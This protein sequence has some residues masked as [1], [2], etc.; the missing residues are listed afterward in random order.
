ME[1]PSTGSRGER[2]ELP[3]QTFAN[4]AEELR[5]YRNQRKILRLMYENVSRMEAQRQAAILLV[6][7]HILGAEDPASELT[8]LKK[9]E[10]RPGRACAQ[11]YEDSL[12]D[13][14][15]AR[16]AYIRHDLEDLN[17]RI[18]SQD[19]AQTE[20]LVARVDRSLKEA[21]LV[22]DWQL[23][24]VESVVGI[25][26][27][28]AQQLGTAEL[29]KLRPV[30]YSFLPHLKGS[31]AEL[32]QKWL[33]LQ[34]K[35]AVAHRANA[36]SKR[37]IDQVVPSARR[38]M[39]ESSMQSRVLRELRSSRSDFNAACDRLDNFSIDDF[40]EAFRL[41]PVADPDDDFRVVNWAHESCDVDLLKSEIGH[42]HRIEKHV[43][44][45]G[46]VLEGVLA[47]GKLVLETLLEVAPHEL[48]KEVHSGQVPADVFD[49][50]SDEHVA[51]VTTCLLLNGYRCSSAL[52]QRLSNSLSSGY[53]P[54]SEYLAA[55][56]FDVLSRQGRDVDSTTRVGLKAA[57]NVSSF[58]NAC[59][60]RGGRSAIEVAEVVLNVVSAVRSNDARAGSVSSELDEQLA[61]CIERNPKLR[62]W[63]NSE[64]LVI[65]Q[66]LPLVGQS[67]TIVANQEM[68]NTG[69]SS[70]M[71]D[72]IRYGR[73][74]AGIQID[75]IGFG[76]QRAW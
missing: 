73:L 4:L 39:S 7:R 66:E 51:I 17:H 45:L 31:A 27:H 3:G 23:R 34:Q 24:D 61:V 42:V 40:P 26:P 69:N 46:A 36:K 44:A 48:A 53:A 20:S 58:V 76:I 6:R 43:H 60:M 16:L 68:A 8:A 37:L 75:A 38:L 64:T 15:A 30:A 47:D 32:L 21:A 50:V 57:E 13:S 41:A 49:I 10:S 14:A 22:V 33:T 72:G 70:R 2:R 25:R 1:N 65:P 54:V 35:T 11:L 71:P 59:I 12:A 9:S 29:A 56:T 52:T 5:R 55:L 19:S 18:I 74:A 63:L 67:M 62:N 28:D